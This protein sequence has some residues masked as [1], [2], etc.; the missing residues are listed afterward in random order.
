LLQDDGSDDD[1]G[2]DDEVCIMIHNTFI[3]LYKLLPLLLMGNDNKKSITL[4]E[5]MIFNQ[6]LTMIDPVNSFIL[7]IYCLSLS[8]PLF[9]LYGI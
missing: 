2:D 3:S 1:Q 8:L 5:S 7:F 6:I 4:S 9:V